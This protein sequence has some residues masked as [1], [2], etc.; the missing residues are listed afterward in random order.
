MKAKIALFP[1]LLLCLSF[2]FT[3]CNS[4]KEVEAESQFSEAVLR[5][6]AWQLNH[7]DVN[8]FDGQ[9]NLTDSERFLFGA[10]TDGGIC[11]FHYADNST[12]TLNDN[13]DV[14]TARYSL[15]DRI[16]YTEGGGTWGIRTMSDDKM[17]IVLRSEETLNPCQYTVSGA[18]YTLTRNQL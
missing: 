10:G 8:S 14:F 4:Q 11:T 15:D 17:E 2:M 13:G 7:V 16:I 3:A 9:G 1:I 5:D 12:W 18:V 6:G